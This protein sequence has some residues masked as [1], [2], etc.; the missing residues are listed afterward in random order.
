L[1][2]NTALELVSRALWFGDH[3][4]EHFESK[5]PLAEPLACQA[6]CH[7]CCFYQV[8][9][10]PPEALLI[11]HYVKRA[12]SREEK[13]DLMN[14]IEGVL[15]RIEGKT[16]EEWAETRHDTP[17]IFL[18]SGKCS[19]YNVRPFVCRSLHALN[20]DECKK[21]FESNSRMAEFEGYSHRYDI[22]QAVKTGLEEVYFH[23]GCQMDTMPIAKAMK[24][25]LENAGL[26]QAWIRGERVFMV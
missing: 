13:S 2:E 15:E 18:T 1:I 25:C 12:Y 3:I 7:Y 16:V 21:A 4:V 19:V 17:C 20:A 8:C 26:S 23:M 5:E 22:Y 10:T 6:G 24:Q 14:R 11:A 9:L